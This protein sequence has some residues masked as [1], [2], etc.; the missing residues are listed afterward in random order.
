M[1]SSRGDI[2][3]G[4]QIDLTPRVAV[5]TEKINLVLVVT[6]N[7]P[8]VAAGAENQGAILLLSRFALD[9]HETPGFLIGEVIPAVTAE[10]DQ[11][12]L[13]G[14]YEGSE[15]GRLSPGADFRRCHDF[16]LGKGCD[17]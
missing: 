5:D 14:R 4:Y 17:T 10:R 11:D 1:G 8:D 16:T 12:V 13:T 6:P 2:F 3:D 15:D 7:A 9:S